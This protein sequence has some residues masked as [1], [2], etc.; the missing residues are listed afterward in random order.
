MIKKCIFCGR[1]SSTSKSV[2][3]II[4]ESLGNDKFIMEKGYVC[5]K[6]NNYFSNNVENEFLNLSPIKQCRFLTL[7]ESKK[8]RVPSGHCSINGEVGQIDFINNTLFVGFDEKSVSKILINK[9]KYLFVPSVSMEDIKI[10]ENNYCV[11]RFLAKITYEFLVYYY[12]KSLKLD[13]D[14][15]EIII[16]DNW[17]KMIRDYAKIGN[18]KKS[19]WPY[20]VK[21]A[22]DK[23]DDLYLKFNFI[24]KDN[25]SYSYFLC[26][27]FEFY[28]KLEQ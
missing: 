13:G 17:I 22:K 3:H 16:Q 7:T 14:E 11:A 5:D 20:I 9:P 26:G 8:G 10:L 12:V 1:D 19:V 2:E 4:P 21:I 24:N 6:C 28:F 23:D 25:T 27:N 15:E 18:S